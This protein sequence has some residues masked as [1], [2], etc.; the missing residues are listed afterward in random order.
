MRLASFKPSGCRAEPGEQRSSRL[1]ESLLKES[2][3]PI[4][5][6]QDEGCSALRFTAIQCETNQP[7]GRNGWN[8]TVRKRNFLAESGRTMRMDDVGAGF[9]AGQEGHPGVPDG[10]TLV[11]RTWH[12][13]QA[14]PPEFRARITYGPALRNER[15]T[16]SA[17][18]PDQV[19]RV[20]QQW[21]LTQTAVPGGN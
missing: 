12:E 16:V 1:R 4:A 6:R 13:H 15:T 19:L 3:L 9:D 2:R 17:A 8:Q 11:I 10:G 7:T 20:V 5:V 18:D 14:Q 21:L